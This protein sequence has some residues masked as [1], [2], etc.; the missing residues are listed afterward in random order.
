MTAFYLASSSID[1]LLSMLVSVQGNQPIIRY[2]NVIGP[3]P[4]TT[5]IP[6][7]QDDKGNPTPAVPAAGILGNY[8]VSINIEGATEFPTP[9]PIGVV[10]DYANGI[11]VLGAWA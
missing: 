9:L 11:S 6:A 3:L 4:A 7:G 2:E 8:Y 5:Y 10:E 1:T